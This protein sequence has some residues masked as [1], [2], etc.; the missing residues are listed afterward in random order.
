VRD[1]VKAL[2]RPPLAAAL[3]PLVRPFRRRLE[4]ARDGS[5]LRPGISAVVAARN[6]D[7][8][9]SFCLRSLVGFADQI[10]CID[11]G[12][13]DATLQ[14]MQEFQQRHGAQVQVDVLSLPGALLGECREAGLAASRHEW[15]LRWDADMV[16]KTTGPESILQLRE[17]V[18]E[19]DRPRAYQLPRT[20]L[21]GDLHHAYRHVSVVDPGEPILV[22]FSR[23]LHY[24]EFGKF[25]VIRLPLHYDQV[26]ERRRY[27]F[28]LQGLKSDANL[29]HRFHYFE[30]RRA[31]NA[32][33]GVVERSQLADFE[34]FKRRRNLE[35]FGTLDPRAIKFRFGRQ[36][37]LVLRRFD[38]EEYG[39]YPEILKEELNTSQRFQVLYRE[40]RPY[41]RL[42]REDVE[43]AGYEPT[44]EDLEWDPVAFVRRFSTP[45]QCRDLGLPP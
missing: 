1:K 32:A 2:L 37:M 31:V 10:V 19:D 7:Y 22:R 38:A 35:L 23:G 15:H 14:R 42:D 25:D 27:Y 20:N 26:R 41:R 45:S 44:R 5:P 8:T 33:R 28:H 43:M 4:I 13:D 11:N 17:K 36:L 39:D 34:E 6:E 24:R 12:S 16:A 9:I 30:W 40:G 3:W 18:L 29:L 21:F